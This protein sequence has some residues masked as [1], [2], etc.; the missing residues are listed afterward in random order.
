MP[1]QMDNATCTTLRRLRLSSLLNQQQH[2]ERCD[3]FVDLRELGLTGQV[4]SLLFDVL[5]RNRDGFDRLI[6]GGGSNRRDHH[7]AAFTSER[8]DGPRKNLGIC[9]TRRLQRLGFVL[10]A[11][12]A[13]RLLANGQQQSGVTVLEV[14]EF[15]LHTD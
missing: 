10:S 8:R 9:T 14:E 3:T 6:D 13:T 4:D 7:S 5:A 1:A 15:R 11:A 12:R 2:T